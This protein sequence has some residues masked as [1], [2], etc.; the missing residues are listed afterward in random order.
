[1]AFMGIFVLWLIL[2]AVVVGTIVL[3][4]VTWLIAR[5]KYRKYRALEQQMQSATPVVGQIMD[6]RQLHGSGNA[7]QNGKVKSYQSNAY[8]F[9]YEF[10]V[11]YPC[12]DGMQHISYFG[13][14]CKTPLPYQI[15]DS[16]SMRMFPQPLQPIPQWVLDETRAVDGY[17][18]QTIYHNVWQGVPV[19]E[20]ATVMLDA[21]YQNLTKRFRRKRRIAFVFRAFGM[22]L[23]ILCAVMVG[24]ILLNSLISSL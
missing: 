6:C 18:P 16:V 20:T 23:L 19:D 17:L 10:A 14:R 15:A 24:G 21:D 1:M 9:L 11:A 22:L 5:S 13:L 7:K 4:F 2:S 3:S 8:P 12:S